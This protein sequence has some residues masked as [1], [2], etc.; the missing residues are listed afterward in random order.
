M[1]ILN[2][3]ILCSFLTEYSSIMVSAQFFPL[4]LKEYFNAV[5]P[6]R[7]AALSVLGDGLSKPLPSPAYRPG[8][9]QTGWHQK[10]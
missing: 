4:Y 9:S 8:L 3:I 10:Q 7:D 5:K 2:A 6:T 1:D